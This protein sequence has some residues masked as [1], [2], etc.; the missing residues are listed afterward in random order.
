MDDVVK[1]KYLTLPE[2]EIRSLDRPARSQSIY[3]LR[4]PGFHIGFSKAQIGPRHIENSTNYVGVLS[5]RRQTYATIRMDQS[6]WEANS[7]SN[8]HEIP[9]VCRIRNLLLCSKDFVTGPYSEADES[10][11][12]AYI[13]LFKI[14][15]SLFSYLSPSFPS[16]LVP[17]GF[18]LNFYVR[19]SFSCPASLFV[20]NLITLAIFT[21]ENIRW[22]PH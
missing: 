17:S 2:L 13:I 8:V 1:R 9:T 10:S 22:R 11:P 12:R 6:P 7:S 19:L 20:L 14:F 5:V 21:E 3:R 16:G 4:Y 15:L 18:L